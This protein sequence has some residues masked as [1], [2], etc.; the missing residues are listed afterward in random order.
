VFN[1]REQKFEMQIKINIEQELFS[2][3]FLEEKKLVSS[4]LHIIKK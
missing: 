1:S 4:L 3:R 2:S